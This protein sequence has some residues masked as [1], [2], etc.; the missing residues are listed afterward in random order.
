MEEKKIAEFGW[1][2][3]CGQT[4][5]AVNEAS[6]LEA[7]WLMEHASLSE[8][9]YLDIRLRFL[10]R[11]IL[12][13][14]YKVVAESKNLRP[15]LQ[16]FK[17]GVKGQ[18]ADCIELTLRD[19]L[20][21]LDLPAD[22]SKLR[23]SFN[24]G[25]DGSGQHSDF[26]QMSKTHYST[27]SI[28]SVC[29]AVN[30]IGLENGVTLWSSAEKGANKPQNVRPLAL[31]PSKETDDL[32]KEFIPL[33]DSEVEA[34]KQ[35]GINSELRDGSKVQFICTK[36]SMS[37][38]DGKMVTRLLQ[39]GG[40]YCSMCPLSESACNNEEN[41]SAGFQI[42]RNV[43]SLKDLAV[44]LADPESGLIPRRLNDYSVRQGITAA[45]ITNADVT[46]H[47][48]VC[49]S[50]IRG[51]EWMIELLIRQNSHQK[52][53][54]P[55]APIRYDESE[56]EAYRREYSRLKLD[57]KLKLAIDIGDPADMV[58]GTAFKTFSSDNARDILASQISDESKKQKFKEIHLGLCAVIR[59][60]NS[61]K[62]KIQ[63]DKLKDLSTQTYLKIRE[64]FPWAYISPS[65]HRILG[66][67]WERILL[68]QKFGL[69]NESE[70]GLEALNKL[71]R[72]LRAHGARTTSSEMNFEDTFH[73]LWRR[74]SPIIAEMEREKKKQKSKIIVLG[75]ID[76]LVESMF[77]AEVVS[78]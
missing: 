49:H 26:N 46:K 35:D 44:S 45:P 1:S 48:P 51:F 7:I 25:L 70:E 33:L 72:Y 55:Q 61:Q 76:S 54:L 24:Y 66:H 31:F 4:P 18:L 29:F 38:I 9:V 42:T 36:A 78:N 40:A 67:S 32:L 16:F 30:E 71:I 74:S 62:K 11:F 77:E 64:T 58:T 19:R 75:E 27:A 73:H 52:W 34:I 57:L 59:L 12:P 63:I 68:N 10:D 22:V 13:P 39:L 43:S 41:I 69:G 6:T 8:S 47:I 53:S 20:S 5:H 60:I 21:A 15:K 2:I 50:K 17:N 23:F 28:M 56:K 14:V 3:F 65:V 37:M